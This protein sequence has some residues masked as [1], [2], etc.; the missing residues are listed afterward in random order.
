MKEFYCIQ[1]G[2]QSNSR[3]S[4]FNEALFSE[5]PCLYN[6]YVLNLLESITL[7]HDE[8]SEIN[9]FYNP[10]NQSICITSGLMEYLWLLSYLHYDLYFQ[11][12]WGNP[13]IPFNLSSQPYRIDRSESHQE[14][15]SRLTAILKGNIIADWPA[16]VTLPTYPYDVNDNTTESKASELM[17][18]SL[19]VI[20][21]HELGHHVSF[22]N[23]FHLPHN[24]EEMFADWFAYTQFVNLS[25]T[26]YL[27]ESH[28][29]NAIQ[30]RFF[31]SINVGCFLLNS[32]LAQGHGAIHPDGISRLDAIIAHN[33][34]ILNLSDD[35]LYN[36]REDKCDMRRV[37][38]YAAFLICVS[39]QL[40]ID[41][42]DI[43]VSKIQNALSTTVFE[44]PFYA[45][46]KMRAE[47][48]HYVEWKEHTIN[49]R[50]FGAARDFI[51]SQITR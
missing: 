2:P 33:S 49:E 19:A 50:A 9:A 4:V 10:A 32:N 47:L 25:A 44:S 27:G 43:F 51:L 28:Y 39:S 1:R 5:L 8:S 17:L 7:I 42:N 38:S 12:P 16:G 41:D 18:H 6:D 31:A 21:L 15:I 26:N 23:N 37:I 29:D 11:T 48:S 46:K 35:R 40:W 24:A 36:P 45:Y 34:N 3:F 22:V 13:E 30:K 20:I 14:I